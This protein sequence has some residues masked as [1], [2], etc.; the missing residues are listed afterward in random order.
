MELCHDSGYIDTF[1]DA[2]EN[3]LPYLHTPEC[4]L[5]PNTFEAALCAIG[6]V[7]NGVE[8]VMEGRI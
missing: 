5:S 4:P 3:G 8:K 1:K 2:V 6:G 7:L